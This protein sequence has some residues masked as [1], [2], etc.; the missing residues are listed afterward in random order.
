M[1]LSAAAVVVV[2]ATAGAWWML[3]PPSIQDAADEYL[4]ALQTGDIQTIEAMT[5]HS[6]PRAA[7]ETMRDAFTAADAYI[8]AAHIEGISSDGSVR[9]TAELSGSPVTVGFMLGRRGRDYALTG[10]FLGTLSVHPTLGAAVRVG[11]AVVPAGAPALLL[12]AAYPVSALPD[13]ILH[14]ARTVAVTNA[15]PVDAELDVSLAPDAAAAAE[16]RLAGYEDRCAESADSVPAHCGLRVPWAADLRTLDEISFRIDERPV[17]A[18]SDDGATFA[19]TGGSITATARGKAWDG[20][21]R[22]VAYR[23]DDWSLRGRVLFDGAQMQL[24]VD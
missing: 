14:G 2:A 19:A 5:E 4:Q 17:L 9:A 20:A 23:T 15:R 3:R 10:D 24:R 7:R 1:A 12:P 18:L 6:L 22:T 16:R 13:D 11:G 21:S 8:T